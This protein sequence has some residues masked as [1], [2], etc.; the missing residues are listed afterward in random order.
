MNQEVTGKTLLAIGM[1]LCLVGGIVWKFGDRL[2]W[3][4]R[5]PGDLHYEGEHFRFYFPLTTLLLLNGLIW[6]ILKIKNWISKD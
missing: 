2:K 1:L 6:G 3:I 5:L 4:G